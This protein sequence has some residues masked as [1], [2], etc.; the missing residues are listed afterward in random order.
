M[1]DPLI[2]Q[3][4]VPTGSP[5][6]SKLKDAGSAFMDLFTFSS[7]AGERSQ[8]RIEK[9]TTPSDKT[10]DKVMTP[11]STVSRVG[12]TLALI[13][14]ARYKDKTSTPTKVIDGS[15]VSLKT[16]Q[17]QDLIM[18]Q[19][20][21]Q[22]QKAL[23]SANPSLWTSPTDKSW[24]VNGLL[25]QVINSPQF[26]ALH[27]AAQDMVLNKIFDEHVAPSMMLQGLNPPS[28][29]E[30]VRGATASSPY[31]EKE[32]A[33]TATGLFGAYAIAGLG[34]FYKAGANVAKWLMK[35]DVPGHNIRNTQF[36]RGLDDA[37][38][39]VYDIGN[40][41][42]QVDT[43]YESV[44]QPVEGWKGTTARLGGS[45]IGSLPLFAAIDA[46][47]GAALGPGGLAVAPAGEGLS[48][49]VSFLAK[50]AG[51]GLVRKAAYLSLVDGTEMFAAGKI[52]GEDT[53]QA[54]KEAASAMILG[55]FIHGAFGI[56]SKLRNPLGDLGTWLRSWGAAKTAA[57]GQGLNNAVADGAGQ[58]IDRMHGESPLQG[59]DIHKIEVPASRSDRVMS[60]VNPNDPDFVAASKAEFVARDQVAN[61]F[62]GKG[63]KNLSQLQRAKVINVMLK[64]QTESAEL[65]PLTH[66]EVVQ[67]QNLENVNGL[68][69]KT[70]ATL[71]AMNGGKFDAQDVATMTTRTQA[72]QIMNAKGI[73]G[74]G[75]QLKEQFSDPTKLPGFLA[76]SAPRYGAQTPQ[77][78]SDLDKA[79]YIVAN[80]RTKSGAHDSFMSWIRTQLPGKTDAEIQSM[81][82]KVKYEVGQAAKADP[83]NPKFSVEQIHESYN[84]GTPS[85]STSPVD[86]TKFEKDPAFQHAVAEASQDYE[87][88]EGEWAQPGARPE[89]NELRMRSPKNVLRS[90]GARAIDLTS[91]KIG[92]ED[93]VY[94]THKY[95]PKT[96]A[97]IRSGK[98][99]F[100][101]PEHHLLY[102][103]ELSNAPAEV[104]AK[105]FRILLKDFGER[106]AIAQVRGQWLDHHLEMLK[107]GGQYHT[108]GNVFRSEKLKPAQY[109]TK[110]KKMLYQDVLNERNSV[111]GK[112]AKTQPTT[113]KALKETQKAMINAEMKAKTPSVAKRIQAI[114]KGV[115]EDLKGIK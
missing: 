102:I 45:L 107:E 35:S 55:P 5:L 77:F 42:S 48:V 27:P 66:P 40:G 23:A 67:A 71:A 72:R 106:K 52:Q 95:L 51:Y 113:A 78:D 89:I 109:A 98:L 101:N 20:G 79:L 83:L 16:L 74:V 19:R 33:G 58:V 63:W 90:V 22:H 4:S 13:A 75:D 93:F 80:S 6:V 86:E 64:I 108:E 1:A 37:V 97:S 18:A 28:Y 46:T 114:G 87:P 41:L 2:A 11:G 96:D 57:G 100:E 3:N 54:A 36:G 53:K 62:Y 70:K 39:R 31:E 61:H 82:Q 115:S 85:T 15:P 9:V 43:S 8:K 103:A 69:D 104:K 38:Q 81:G 50:K 34:S 94:L 24:A 47:G 30:W 10:L 7:E 60:L 17:G 110:W 44:F 21:A 65:M 29:E 111:L 68:D 84:P 12:K 25:H 26:S 91:S 88:K 73:G 92:S 112:L 49:A 99:L 32:E 76:K 105:A 56:A 14:N 59:I